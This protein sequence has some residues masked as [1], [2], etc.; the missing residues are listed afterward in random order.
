MSP[1]L[2]LTR[3]KNVSIDSTINNVLIIFSVEN[4]CLLRTGVMML[5]MQLTEIN[6]ILTYIL[7]K[8]LLFKIQKYFK[9]I[10]FL[11]K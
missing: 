4:S 3:F 11:I 8:K 7:K 5:K 9:I 2:W 10:V 6:Y 1:E